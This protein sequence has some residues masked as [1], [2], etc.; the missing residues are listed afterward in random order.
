MI[1]STL[2]L[3]FG[4]AKLKKQ[5]IMA[6]AVAV[7]W[8]FVTYQSKRNDRLEEQVKHYKIKEE[9][10]EVRSRPVPTDRKSILDRM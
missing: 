9:A 7:F 2:K 8:A 5:V 3:V 10:D 6:G 1:I 4:W